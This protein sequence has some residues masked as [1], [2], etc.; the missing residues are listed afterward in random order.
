LLLLRLPL[1]LTLSPLLLTL[2]L[3]LLPSNWIACNIKKPP[4]GGFFI[5]LAPF[6]SLLRCVVGRCLVASHTENL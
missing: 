2:L 5:A 1:L 6:A 4:S 3:L